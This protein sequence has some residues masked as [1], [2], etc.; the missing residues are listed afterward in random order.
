MA[1]IGNKNIRQQYFDWMY[2]LVCDDDDVVPSY[3]DLLHCLNE[4]EFTYIL[5]M[6]GN[7]ASDGVELRYRF[8]YENSI[9]NSYIE[10]YLDDRPCSVLEMMVALAFACEEHIMD[11]PDI[12]NRTSEWFWD[13]IRNLGLEDMDDE[14]FDEDYAYDV[15]FRFLNRDYEPNG[16]GG[17][18][19]LNHCEYDLRTIDI[20][21]QL[22][23]FLNENFDFSI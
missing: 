6:D 4:I 8:G 16:K 20:W 11:D 18:F 12:G 2:Y 10:V 9:P 7:R 19:T 17:L 3:R 13:M 1:S 5:E 22:M 21:Y 23:W 15:I 14:N